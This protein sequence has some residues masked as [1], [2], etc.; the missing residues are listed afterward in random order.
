MPWWAWPTILSLDAPLV[1][2]AW[3]ALFFGALAPAGAPRPAHTLVL[4][5]SVWL[6]YAADRWLD[7]FAFA[8]PVPATRRHAFY[9]GR[10]GP[11]LAI[12]VAVLGLD[13]TLA[14]ATLSRADLARGLVL[15]GATLLYLAAVQ[16]R[17]GPL[18][19][20]PKEFQVALL[21][22]AGAT[23]F[24]WGAVGLALPFVL[25]AA[26]CGLNCLLIAR[27]EAP[28]AP[29]AGQRSR[30]DGWALALTLTALA[31]AV[32]TPWPAGALH[33]ATGLGAAALW[34]LHRSQDRLEVGLRRVLAD[35]ALLTPLLLLP[36]VL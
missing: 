12:W 3:Q 15:L 21:F 28:R 20:L 14:L 35:A 4:F 26:L 16:L 18:A 11:F 7:G 1:A 5:L 19:R 33:L 36:F 31:A 34:G 13:L 17:R 23:L 27:W 10:R 32:A 24:V 2:V 25:F 8:D 22:A 9:A 30:L 29:S 6:V